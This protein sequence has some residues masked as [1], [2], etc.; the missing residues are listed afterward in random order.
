M[1]KNTEIIVIMNTIIKKTLL[2]LFTIILISPVFPQKTD[3]IVIK[4]IFNEALSNDIAYK[5]LEYLCKKIGARICGS[6]QAA[7]AVEWTK[8][9]LQNMDLDNVYIEELW[10]HR[11]DRGE[12]EYSKMVSNINGTKELNICALGE[13]IGTKVEGINA[14]VIEVKN[15][16]EL[17][18]L[19]KKKIK[20]KIVFFNRPMDPT[21]YNTFEAY[22]GAADQR[23]HGASEAAKYGAIGVIVRSLTTNIDEFPHTGIMF[24]TAGVEK[25]PAVGVCTKDA[26]LLSIWLKSDPKLKLFI[27]TNCMFFPEVKSGNVVGEI[28]GVQYPNEFITVGGH[29]DSWDLGEGAHDDGVGCIQSIEVLRLFKSL[30]IKPKHTIRVVIFMDEEIAQK[31]GTKH[32]ELV[33]LKNEKIIAAIESDGGGFL[34]IGFSID[35][36]E[37]K[38]AKLNEWIKLFENYGMYQIFVGWGGVDIEPLKELNIPLFGLVTNSQRYF[39]YQH[40]ANDTFEKVNKREMQLGSGAMAALVYLIDQNGL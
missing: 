22:G 4:K 40:S 38:I 35:A 2:F 7:A 12:K 34:P 16:E 26:E 17:K 13:S 37:E 36:N 1:A 6:P 19:G 5:N 33:E 15:F 30:D 25:I 10:V 14:E 28:K 39:D 32:K 3:S 23:V 29:I 9:L 21:L 31:G 11:W 27:K 24:Y 8:Q 18:K 20:G